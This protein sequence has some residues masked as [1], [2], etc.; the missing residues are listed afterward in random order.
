MVGDLCL[1]WPTDEREESPL[2]LPAVSVTGRY[3]GG[4]SGSGGPAVHQQL[5]RSGRGPRLR[6]GISGRSLTTP[7]APQFLPFQ[8]TRIQALG[9]V[10][11]NDLVRVHREG[12]RSRQL[13]LSIPTLRSTRAS[14]SPLVP[15][16]SSPRTLRAHT[17]RRTGPW[18]DVCCLAYTCTAT[19]T[20]TH[21]LRPL[22]CV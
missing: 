20:P 13:L 15:R 5:V 3:S 2:L 8:G 7:R 16:L 11:A 21:S 18:H 12:C 4:A 22:P 19:P 6:G 9:N 1:V 14:P 10:Q 17:A